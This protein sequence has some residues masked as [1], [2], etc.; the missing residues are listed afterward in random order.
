[1][2]AYNELINPHRA[3]LIK[4]AAALA[5][6]IHKEYPKITQEELAYEI[7]VRLSIPPKQS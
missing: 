6:E 3:A 5:Q 2:D 7:A 4:K 1:M